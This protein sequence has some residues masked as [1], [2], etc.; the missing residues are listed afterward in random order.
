MHRLRDLSR[1]EHVFGLLHPDLPSECGPLRSLDVL[2]NNL[3]GE[4]TPFVGRRVELA[5]IAELLGRARLLTLTGAGGCGKTRLA[6]QTAADA[7]DRH[8]DGVWWIELAPLED[9]AVLSAT[10]IAT[11][12]LRELPG[13][14]PLD[15]LIDHLQGRTVLILLDNCEHLLSDC[16][17]LVDALLRACP[18]LTILAT[19]RA[20]LGVPG[21]T[22]WRV[23]SMSLPAQPRRES[24]EVLSQYDAIRLFIDRAIQVRP[25]F[26]IN[27]DNALA[28]AQICHELDGI[29]LAIELAAARMR[30]LG[31]EQIARGLSNRFHLLTG[32]SG[33]VMPRHRTLQA[34]IDWSYELLNQGER[35]L[36]RR[37]SVF[38]GGWT[39]DAAEEVCTGDGIDHQAVLDLLT[40]LVDKSLVI[41]EELG[42]E[43]RC[44][45]LETVREYAKARLIEA[46]E[47]DVA[48]GRHLAYYLAL[49]DRSEP[50]VLGAEKDGP[51]LRRLTAEMPNMRAALEHATA[52]DPNAGLRITA[53]LTLFWLFTGRYIEAEAA[54]ARALDAASE[55]PTALRGRVLWGR[56]F[57][58]LYA[59]S[60]ETVPDWVQA[61]LEIGEIS[62]DLSLQAR[63]YVTVGIMVGYGGDP[64]GGRRLL[65]RSVELARQGDDH[66]CFIEALQCLGFCWIFQDEFDIARPLFDEAYARL[67]KL[68][69]RWG[70]GWHWIALGLEATYQGRLKDALDLL[71]RAVAASEAVGDPVQNGYGSGLISYIQIACGNVHNARALA[72]DTVRRLEETGGGMGLGYV[73]Q[74]LAKA[75]LTT[76]EFAAAGEHLKVAI[77]VDRLGLTYVLPEHLSL[78]G[79]LER[80]AENADAA[81]KHGEE[82]LKLA[83]QVGSGLMQSHAE[84]LLGR[85]AIDAGD[86][87][88][89]E[90]YFRDALGRLVAKSF[91]LYIPESL[92][93]L[94]ATAAA[95]ESFEQAARLFGAAAACRK[96]LGLERMPPEPEFWGNIEFTTRETLGSDAYQSAFDAGAAMGTD[97]AVAYAR[98]TTG[99]QKRPSTAGTASRR[100]NSRSYATSPPK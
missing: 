2:P 37:L 38:T 52:T 9:P 5:A 44:S 48:R 29:P 91:A 99:E 63:A 39:I 93:A 67:T 77:E 79:T 18:S 70:I 64:A 4:L 62:G 78:L 81:Y 16:A 97:D 58:G 21:E 73:H 1:P 98:R 33:T 65:E 57:I 100:P 12:R 80:I 49:A 61:A 43:I 28:V 17:Q 26:T 30:M 24:I 8:Q 27:V 85:L 90:R 89:A 20:P 72:E 15:V 71:A 11:L 10:V 82:A 56:A 14:A 32:G 25:S 34:S 7:L 60:Q 23:P 59:G 46:G 87:K 88:Q 83:R 42:Q 92:D 76:S 86:T 6:L 50:Q 74:V 69:Y 75:E 22:V 96:R 84:H 53:A 47:V 3:P 54:Y 68:S 40:G 35:M 51:L 66:W 36:L 45:L 94:A 55:E 31:P 13:R 95:Q 19:S 41:T